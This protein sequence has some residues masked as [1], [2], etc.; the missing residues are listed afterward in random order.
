MKLGSTT[1]LGLV[2]D[3]YIC[4]IHASIGLETCLIVPNKVCF[5]LKTRYHVRETKNVVLYLFC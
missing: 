5:G 4:K 3:K 2:Q 1:K